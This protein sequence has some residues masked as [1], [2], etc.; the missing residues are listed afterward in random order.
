MVAKRIGQV[1]PTLSSLLD[2]YPAGTL[3]YG[4]TTCRSVT[5]RN[6]TEYSRTYHACCSTF[7]FETHPA[8]WTRRCKDVVERISSE[9]VTN[10]IYPNR[11]SRRNEEY[12]LRSRCRNKPRDVFVIF[13]CESRRVLT[14]V[15]HGPCRNRLFPDGR[16]L[17]VVRTE[18]MSRPGVM[19]VPP[20][21]K[22]FGLFV[23]ASGCC[24]LD[25]R[26][27]RDRRGTCFLP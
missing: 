6:G 4:L 21:A 17:Y 11:R 22:P 26:G 8:E 18:G 1:C 5:I 12:Q 23:R 10:R 20:F 9:G 19:T 3:K 25:K 16:N 27:R 14:S 2:G 13:A 24:D 15:R 7:I